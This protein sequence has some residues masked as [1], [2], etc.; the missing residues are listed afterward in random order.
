[1]KTPLPLGLSLLVSLVAI[2]SPLAPAKADTPMEA[3]FER[4][5][6]AYKKLGDGLKAPQESAKS[7][8]VALAEQ[9]RKEGGIVRELQPQMIG[10]LPEA[11]R[12]AFLERFRKDMDAFNASADKLVEALK[13]ANWD[14]ASKL[15]Q[16]LRQDKKEGHKTFRVKD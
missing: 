15:M 6:K 8:Y 5:E 1:M 3:A 13:N 2:F 10:T 11:E 12:P 7:T 16:T 9:I 4:L 14:E